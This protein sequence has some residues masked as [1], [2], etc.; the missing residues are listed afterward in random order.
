[1]ATRMYGGLYDKRVAEMLEAR[2]ADVIGT[3]V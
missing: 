2:K 1:M 3:E